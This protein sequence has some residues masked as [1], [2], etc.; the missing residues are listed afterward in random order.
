MVKDNNY[1]KYKKNNGS[2][3]VTT[4]DVEADSLIVTSETSLVPFPI[5]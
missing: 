1:M 4:S 2:S 5:I 3:K